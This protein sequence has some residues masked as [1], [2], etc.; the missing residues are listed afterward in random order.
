M[1]PAVA[2]RAAALLLVLCAAGAA[3]GVSAQGDSCPSAPVIRPPLQNMTVNATSVDGAIVTYR[4]RS[5]RDNNGS[6]PIICD[7]ASGS[8]FA[9]GSTTVTCTAGVTT[10]TFTVR[11]A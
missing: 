11:G 8:Q 7:P 6:I 3:V 9:I 4:P 1:P 5:A 10:E 2:A